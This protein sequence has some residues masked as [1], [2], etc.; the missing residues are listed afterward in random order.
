MAERIPVREVQG[1]EQSSGIVDLFEIE[2]SSTSRAYITRGEDSDLGDVQMYDYDTNSQLNTYTAIP[3]EI[4]GVDVTTKGVTARP[5]VTISNILTD[6][7]TAI[8]P[9][10]YQDLV[11]KKLYR[12]RTLRKYLKDGSADPGSGN[13]PIEFPRQMWV[14]DRVEQE[15]ALQIAF[16]LSSPFN[17]E[18]L[19]LPY[20]VVGH[21][22]CPWQYQGASPEKT[23]ANK[24]GGCT[25]HSESKYIIKGTAYQVYV[26]ADDEYVIPSSTSFT[27]WAGSGTAD[28]YYKTTTTLGT[29][30]GVRRYKADGTVDTSADGTTVNNYWQAVRATSTTPSDTSGDWNRIRVFSNY[31][32]ST[33]YYAY[34]DDKLNDYAKPTS[35]TEFLWQTKITQSNNTQEFGKYWRRG[36]LCGK[37]LSS[38]QCRYGFN[39]ISSGTASSTGKATKLTDKNLPFGGFPGARKFK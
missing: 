21:N 6:F 5:V 29:S 27:T 1:L 14:I 19:V 22:A 36:D 39:P 9:L 20:R 13:A 4:E 18:G 35:G 24:R 38:C 7:E 10:N 25:W 37:R 30:S 32:T 34:T 15:D 33:I 23:E 17:T 16:E 26:N 11:G 8:S 12:R 3:I 28:A 2:L 31:S